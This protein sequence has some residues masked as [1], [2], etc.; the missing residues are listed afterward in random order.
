M[1]SRT[2][3]IVLPIPRERVFRYLASIQNLPRWATEFCRELKQVDGKHKVVT[4]PALGKQE[5]FF[6]ICADEKTGVIDMLAGPTDDRMAVF[7]SRVLEL[8]DGSSAFI[9]TMFQA[10]ETDDE[11][12]AMQYRSLQKEFENIRKELMNT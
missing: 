2:A 3:V 10:S 5:L 1:N 11:Q 9:F 8:A 12:F 4:C 7:P 6:Q